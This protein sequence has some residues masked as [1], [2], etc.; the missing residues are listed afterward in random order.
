MSRVSWQYVYG[1]VPSRRLGRSLGIDLVPPKTCTF[2]CVYC[3]LGRTTCRTLH[4]D[5]YHPVEPMLVELGEALAANAAPDYI[6]LA[7]S[8]EPTLHSQLADI[9]AG[10]RKRTTVPVVVLTNGS[11]LW[12]EDVRR[13]C[14]QADAVLP[15]LAA[16]DEA[17]F[18]R[19][20]RPAAGLSLAR[21]IDGL[22]AFTRESNTPLW[23]ELF[24]LAGINDSP[25]DL[26]AFAGLI[27]R[28][29]PERVHLNT[30]VRPTSDR[31]IRP[32]S[33]ETLAAWAERLGPAAEVIV[34]LARET[35]PDADAAEADVLALCRRRPCTIEHIAT[36]LGVHPNVVIKHVGHLREQGRLRSE[37]RDG[38][39]FFVA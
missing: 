26:E 24:L 18:Q 7:G 38:R 39:E 5:V 14:A 27:E 15:T 19:V 28:I 2:D 1:P 10:V 6:T 17:T 36:G 16:H 33:A 35:G 21:H 30:A 8:G 3:Q 9:V 11:L 13:A 4:R 31:D 20:H 22:L 34:E 23:L 32:V 37:W 25:D 12:D 29:R